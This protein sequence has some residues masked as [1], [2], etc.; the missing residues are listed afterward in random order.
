M[1]GQELA[2]AAQFKLPIIVLVFNNSIYGTIRMHQ[3]REYPARVI[4]TDLVNPSFAAL[5]D[6][7]H[8]FGATV[9]KTS[10]FEA[11]FEEALASGKPALIEII[12]DPEAI[13]PTA[14]LSGI[15][16]AAQNKH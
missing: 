15:R 10:E 4:G 8:C 3:E 12:T 1:T 9:H 6:A 2:T 5:A 11:A 7:Y 13:S 16:K 14:T